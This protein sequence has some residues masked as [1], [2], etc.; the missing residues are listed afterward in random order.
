M[1][2]PYWDHEWMALCRALD[3]WFDNDA[4]DFFMVLKNY[5]FQ[6]LKTLGCA[7]LPAL[8]IGAAITIRPRGFESGKQKGLINF[9]VQIKIADGKSPQRFS[10]VGIGDGR[11][12]SLAGMACLLV[13]MET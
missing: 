8:A 13:I 3:K 12:T 1:A 11:K 7:I 10:M 6:R 5:L 4:A 2:A 9:A